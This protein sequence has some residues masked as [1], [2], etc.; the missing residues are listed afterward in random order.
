MCSKND[1]DLA[2]ERGWLLS[3]WLDPVLFGG[4]SLLLLGG[5]WLF[6]RGGENALLSSYGWLALTLFSFPHFMAS[7]VI[8]YGYREIRQN[9]SWIAIWIPLILGLLLIGVSILLPERGLPALAH[10]TLVLLYWHF[11]KQT[12]G[13]ALWLGS[14]SRSRLNENKK[15]LLLLALL[16][17][18]C[19]GFLS[20]ETG[21]GEVNLFMIPAQK[22]GV[23]QWALLGSEILAYGVLA[24]FVVWIGID[25]LFKKQT[26]HWKG[27]IPIASLVCW[28]NPYWGSSRFGMFIPIFHALQYFPFPVRTHLTWERKGSLSRQQRLFFR[29]VVGAGIIL[30]GWGIFSVVPQWVSLMLPSGHGWKVFAAIHILINLHHYFMDAVIWRFRDPLVMKRILGPETP[31]G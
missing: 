13:V 15:Q 5:L 17:F 25:A 9:H 28:F 18:G 14:R 3:P 31:H 7:Y 30:T 6:D 29:F 27:W 10:L 4:G 21:S 26:F 1:K 19:Y 20:F 16:L 11:L 24:G 22:L 12:Y 2:V 8:F 23:A